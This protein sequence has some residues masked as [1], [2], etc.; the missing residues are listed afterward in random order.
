MNREIKFRALKSGTVE[1]VFG[2]FVKNRDGLNFIRDAENFNTYLIER[3]TLGQFTG[4]T[5][6]HEKEIYAGDILHYFQ[7]DKRYFRTIQWFKNSFWSFQVNS[8]NKF[9]ISFLSE[10][11][12]D[13]MEIIGNIFENPELLKS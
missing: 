8:E 12:L 2:Y 3:D 7:G 11:K 10:N 13:D 6:K 1:W 5:D 9:P 4:L